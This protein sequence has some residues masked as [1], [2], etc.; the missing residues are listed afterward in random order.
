MKQKVEVSSALPTSL[1]TLILK[2]CFVSYFAV[3]ALFPILRNLSI[4]YLI[5]FI[6]HVIV[7]MVNAA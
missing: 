6:D 3:C 2:S 1:P 7:N 5:I 4:I